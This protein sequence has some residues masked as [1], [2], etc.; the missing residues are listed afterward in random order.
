[1]A[2]KDYT[3]AQVKNN[4]GVYVKESSPQF[5]AGVKTMQERLAQCGY[6]L[7]SGGADGLFGQT[8]ENIVKAFQ[9]ESKLT[10]DGQ[11]GTGTL[12]QLDKVYTKSEFNTYGKPLTSTQWGQ[13]YILGGNVDD[14]DLLARIIW[15]EDRQSTDA[16]AAVAKVIKNRSNSGR[17]DF[18]EKASDYQNASI[19]ARVVGYKNPI[20]YATAS[21]GSASK[22]P[23]RGDYTKT[24]GLDVYWKNA[25]SLAKKLK[26]GTA[27]TPPNGYVLN[28]D[29]TTSSTKTGAVNS[30]L[31]QGSR[32]QFMN[33]TGAYNGVK[34]SQGATVGTVVFNKSGD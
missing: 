34:F 12:T 16:Q 30:Q 13:D 1:M 9:T 24:D 19:W 14:V 27:F 32:T 28:S 8:T 25:V 20:Q 23:E 29:G 18:I 4:Q 26:D 5:S 17:S 6:N 2:N 11:A 21:A 33:A 22:T 31:W 15:G 10:S 3:Y 7:G